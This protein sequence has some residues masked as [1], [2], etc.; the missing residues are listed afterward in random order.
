MREK[1][2]SQISDGA[3]IE[4]AVDAALAANPEEVEAYRAGKTKLM[5]FF[6]GQVMR[7]MRGKANPA[8]VNATLTRKLG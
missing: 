4:Q 5:S 2:L 6:V 7:A 8:L 3:L 1:G